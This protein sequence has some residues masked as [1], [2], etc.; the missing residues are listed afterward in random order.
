MSRIRNGY[1]PTTEERIILFEVKKKYND[2][3][4]DSYV[5]DMFEKLKKEGKI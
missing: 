1:N 5:D 3:G 4:G 2:L